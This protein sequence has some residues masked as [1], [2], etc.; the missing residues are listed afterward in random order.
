[1]L[2]SCTRTTLEDDTFH[3]L[4][5]RL[6]QGFGG[7]VAAERYRRCSAHSSTQQSRGFQINFCLVVDRISKWSLLDKPPISLS[8]LAFRR[9]SQSRMC[10]CL[11]FS[12][13]SP[14]QCSLCSEQILKFM[15]IC[16][17]LGC[18]NVLIYFGEY[19]FAPL[20][21]NRF[22]MCVVPYACLSCLLL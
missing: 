4:A 21:L 9:V 10:Y 15:H 5:P 11:H 13:L 17:D 2:S 16:M 14:K 20:I 1:M 22:A 18:S 6:G 8:L 3:S 19:F 7:K 12:L